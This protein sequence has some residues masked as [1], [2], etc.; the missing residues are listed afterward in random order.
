[1]VSENMKIR[2]TTWRTTYFNHILN[3]LKIKITLMALILSD[4][5]GPSCWQ[6]IDHPKLFILLLM[7]LKI[8][9]CACSSIAMLRL[10]L[11]HVAFFLCE[12]ILYA[13]N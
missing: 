7:R 3:N 8:N 6:T 2:Q 13:L 11:S 10:S 1:M 4:G 5:D 12:T 9:G